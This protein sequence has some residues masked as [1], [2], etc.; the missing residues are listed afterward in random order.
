MNHFPLRSLRLCGFSFSLAVAG[1]CHS[2]PAE[3]S[4]PDATPSS[5]AVPASAASAPVDA[6]EADGGLRA[7]LHAFCSGAFLADQDW[8]RGKC[9][10]EDLDLSARLDRGAAEVCAKDMMTA[11]GRGRAE[12]DADAG[13]RCVD[14]L[15]QK[16][17]ASTSESDTLFQHFPCDRVLVGKQG[18]GAACLFSVECKDG[19]ACVGYKI[20]VDGTC[21]KPPKV[22]EACTLQ[23]YGSLV[24]E[25]ASAL[26]HPACAPNAYCDGSTCQ[27]RVT[28]GKGCIGPDVCPSGL[29]CV[30]GKC[31]LRAA[32]G[33]SC[34]RATDCA[35]GLRCDLAGGA[36][37]CVAKGSEGQECTAQDQC[38]GRCVFPKKA[39]GGGPPAPGKCASVCGSG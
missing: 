8:M 11:L 16:H 30:M 35:F 37:K 18:E 23:P 29:S 14:M 2:A 39:P 34:A 6:G 1:G 20:G 19:L 21:K 36:G 31:G 33:S 17:L 15:H 9:T 24:N 3:I 4:P 13:A 38:K 10:A 28:A 26:H 22:G 5:S 32:V 7:E 25:Q 12:I 27:P